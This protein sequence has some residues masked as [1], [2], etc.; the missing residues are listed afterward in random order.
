Y[1]TLEYMGY[2]GEDRLGVVLHVALQGEHVVGARVHHAE[3]LL[4][5][6][7]QVRDVREGRGRHQGQIV[8]PVE[9]GDLVGHH[10]LGAELV[11][12]VQLGARDPRGGDVTGALEA[13]LGGDGAVGVEVTPVVL[14]VVRASVV[15]GRL[16]NELER[17]VLVEGQH[18]GE[19]GRQH[20][21]R[22]RV[23]IGAD[24]A[25]QLHQAEVVLVLGEQRDVVV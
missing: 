18:G 19:L 11:E 5:P 17:V 25:V 1:R 14:V 21:P 24:T 22:A 23:I 16:E 15:G 6:G 4:V 2:T 10:L 12:D 20:E 3:Q 9:G 13:G 7:E 8:H